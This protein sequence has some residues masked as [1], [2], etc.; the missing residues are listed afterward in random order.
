MLHRP[1]Q[2]FE[3]MAPEF[4]CLSPT[5]EDSVKAV[6]TGSSGN[7]QRNSGVNFALFRPPVSTSNAA[8][9]FAAPPRRLSG[10]VLVGAATRMPSVRGLI[11]RVTGMQV[12]RLFG[13]SVGVGRL[14][15]VGWCWSVGRYA[16]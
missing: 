5:T 1:T 8:A 3:G 13:W 6:S 7:R 12:S 2:Q 14:V 10:L 9:K 4:K 15:L 11:T 16:G